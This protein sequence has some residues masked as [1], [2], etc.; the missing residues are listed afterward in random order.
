MPKHNWANKKNPDPFY[1]S[2]EWKQTRKAF[3]SSPPL[4]QLPS[5]GGVKYENK[6]CVECWK[7]GKINSERIEIH[8]LIRVKD[9]GDKTKFSNLMSLCHRHHSVIDNNTDKKWKHTSTK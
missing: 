5:I 9:A 2:S 6:Y 1:Q 3:L 8:H 4:I 7:E